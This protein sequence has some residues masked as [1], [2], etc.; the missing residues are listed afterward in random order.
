[1]AVAEGISKIN[2]V[3]IGNI[4]KTG[5]VTK[6]NVWSISGEQRQSNLYRALLENG[7]WAGYTVGKN[8]QS[9]RAAAA[10]GGAGTNGQVYFAYNNNTNGSVYTLTFDKT[11]TQ[12]VRTFSVRIN[13]SADLSTFVSA[14]DISTDS[15]ATSK[16]LTVNNSTALIYIGFFQD[17]TTT[18]DSLNIVD[19]RVTKS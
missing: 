16:T 5:G 9:F 3:A 14:N 12:G 2:G 18:T 10:G 19:F 11:G 6:T 4:T 8:P 1:M 13:T 7:N 17:S 15:G